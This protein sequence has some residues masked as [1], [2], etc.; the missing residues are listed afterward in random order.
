M[1]NVTSRD[2]SQ[3]WPSF[4]TIFLGAWLIALPMT[5]SFLSRSM[6]VS[7]ILCGFLLIALGIWYLC[8]PSSW[9]PWVLSLVGVWLQFAP[10]VFWAPT[11]LSYIND[12]LV[13]ALVIA[14]A[15]LIPKN[16]MEES[17][18]GGE[19]PPGWSYNPSS[20]WQRIPIISLGFLAWMFAR[21]MA[22]FQ[23]G[24][25]DAV[26]DPL[27]GDGTLKVITSNVSK[28]FPVADAGL[29]AM[30]YTVETLMGAHGSPRR[31]HTIPWFV[32][33][34]AFL[35]VP[36]G[37]VSI[38]LIILQP[39]LVGHWCTW[40]LLTAICMLLM[41]ALAM[42]EVVAVFQYLHQL[43]KERSDWKS[44]FWKGGPAL[45]A[46]DDLRTPIVPA[47]PR[48]FA[49]AMLWGISF[50][51]NL[52]VTALIG[53]W[54]MFAPTFLG[55]Q[56]F[57]ADGNHVFGALV[58]ALSIISM[59][60]VVRAGRYLNVLIGWWPILSALYLEGATLWIQ[61]ITGVL[62]ILFSVPKGPVRETYGSWSRYIF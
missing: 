16:D 49:P 37:F 3:I 33:L 18:P 28:M 41:I 54:L 50:P 7:D 62:L 11:A 42:D 26:W 44:L 15:I 53:L 22:A 14:C 36:V 9:L 19:I 59:A 5:I 57:V 60:E 29:G 32:L 13:G 34:F 4:A 27:F 8:R 21:Y 45:E 24:Y 23:L 31:W 2:A 30:A 20:W 58:V 52:G 61:L 47:P 39:I 46:K 48:Q 56:G 51:W 10:L 17:L 55:I 6:I 25:L 35:V 38:V 43:R 40:C 1:P 12:T